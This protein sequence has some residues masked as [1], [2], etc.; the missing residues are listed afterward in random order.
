MKSIEIKG[1]VRKNVGKKATKELRKQDIVPCIVYGAPKNDKGE[2]IVTHFQVAAK[3]LRKLIYT[4]HIYAID[5]NIDGEVKNAI[6]QEV[7]FHPLTDKILHVDFLHIDEQKPIKMNVPVVLEGLAVGVQ[8]GGKLNQQMRKLTV[9]AL[10]TAIPEHIKIDVT[11]LKLGKSIKVGDL[12]FEG[13]EL[14]NPKQSVVCSVKATRTSVETTE[15]AAAETEEATAPA[16][17]KA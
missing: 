5:L 17:D 13:L 14:I 10:Y 11:N 8:A 2:T 12:N 16:D 9:K 4:P 6:L 1:T 3:D 7:Q 15:T